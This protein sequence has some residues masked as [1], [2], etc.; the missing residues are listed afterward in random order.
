LGIVALHLFAGEGPVAT[1]CGADTT[2][3]S[4]LVRETQPGNEFTNHLRQ[5]QAR[6]PSGFTLVWQT[7]FFVVGDEAPATVRLH[8]TTTVKWA[9]DLLKKDYFQKDP[10]PI[11][12]IWLFRDKTSYEKHTREIFRDTATSRFGYY[13]SQHRALFMNISTG[14]GTLVHEIVHPFMEANFRACPPWYNEGLASLYEACTESNGRIRGLINWRLKGLEKAIQER[15]LLPFERLMALEEPEFYGGTSGY[16]EHYA[17]ARYLCYYLQERELLVRFHREFVANAKQDPTG[18]QTLKKILKVNDLE[19]FREKWQKFI[20]D[21][22][23][24]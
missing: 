15:K 3:A 22:R 24:P 13:S 7:P 14:R 21:I 5:L 6:L 8:A 9:V 19:S 1:L 16:S 10:V 20:L 17:Q 2:T 4:P 18:A 12:D 23:N 11:I